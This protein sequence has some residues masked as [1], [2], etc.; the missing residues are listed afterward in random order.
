VADIL[1]VAHD[2]SRQNGI[3]LEFLDHAGD[4]LASGLTDPDALEAMG[5]QAIAVAVAARACDP[6]VVPIRQR[7]RGRASLHRPIPV[8]P[9]LAGQDSLEEAR[10]LNAVSFDFMLV[11]LAALT[12]SLALVAWAALA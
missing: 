5:R 8:A 1:F 2:G 12:L 4:S 3:A 7:P 10:R 6:N 11:A 9:C